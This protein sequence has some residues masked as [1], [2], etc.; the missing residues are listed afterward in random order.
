[1]TTGQLRVPYVAEVLTA[2]GL[3]VTIEGIWEG[4]SSVNLIVR[5]PRDINVPIE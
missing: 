4:G 3:T 2:N 5:E 1:M